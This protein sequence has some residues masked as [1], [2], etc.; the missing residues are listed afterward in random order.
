MICFLIE[1]QALVGRMKRST[2]RHCSQKQTYS[3][4]MKSKVLIFQQT[5]EAFKKPL[6]YL[7]PLNSVYADEGTDAEGEELLGRYRKFDT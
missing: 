5:I 6:K 4:R 1:A 7:V 3:P 2:L